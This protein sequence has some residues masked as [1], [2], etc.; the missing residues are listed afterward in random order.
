MAHDRRNAVRK[1][2]ASFEN[3]LREL[4][5]MLNE[6]PSSLKT[7]IRRTIKRERGH[8]VRIKKALAICEH[9]L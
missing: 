4:Q 8:L 2:V 3:E 9:R 5:G 1:D 6:A 7:V